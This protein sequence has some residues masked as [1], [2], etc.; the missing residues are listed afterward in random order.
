MCLPPYPFPVLGLFLYLPILL[1]IY[2]PL[3]SSSITRDLCLPPYPFPVLGLFLYLPI[4]LI[5]YYPLLSSSITRDLCLPP[6]PFPVLGL[7][8]YLPILLIIYYP[9]L[10]FY[11]QRLGSPSISL[12]CARSNYLSIYPD[13][14]YYPSSF[15]E[16]LNN[17]IDLCLPPYPFTVLDLTIYLDLPY[18]PSSF[19]ELLHQHQRLVSPSISLHCARSNYLS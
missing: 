9:L 15:T 19:T 4:L 7:F 11:H 3:L 2:Y 1:I 16:L 6:Y 13:L 14:P 12:H 17:T 18:Y 10:S 8:L 5:I